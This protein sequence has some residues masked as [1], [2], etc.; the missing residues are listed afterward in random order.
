[1]FKKGSINSDKKYKFL[2]LDMVS[3]DYTYIHIQGVPQKGYNRFLRAEIIQITGPH[4]YMYL[5]IWCILYSLL[6]FTS[7]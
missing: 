4:S 3:K 6:Q 5:H 1:M 7:L 2:N